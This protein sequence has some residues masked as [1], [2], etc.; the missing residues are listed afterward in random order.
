MC[1]SE[2]CGGC[3]FRSYSLQDSSSEEDPEHR[4]WLLPL[5]KGFW[6]FCKFI[7]PSLDRQRTL[8]HMVRIAWAFCTVAPRHIPGAFRGNQG[9]GSLSLRL[10][11]GFWPGK[12][13]QVSTGRGRPHL[14]RSQG[15]Q[16]GRLSHLSSRVARQILQGQNFPPTVL[17]QHLALGARPSKT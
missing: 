14:S 1:K 15:S 8:L 3:V 2:N 9:D 10:V 16:S 5:L 4:G 7:S 17:P 6:T 13:A 11:T 12:G